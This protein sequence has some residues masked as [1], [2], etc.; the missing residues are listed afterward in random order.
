MRIKKDKPIPV[1][2]MYCRSAQKDAAAIDR[3]KN[4]LVRYAA[5]HGITKYAFYID[6]GEAGMRMDR[7][8]FSK[9]NADIE[10][11]KVGLV[12]ALDMSRVGRDCLQVMEWLE[13]LGHKG[14]KFV[15]VVNDR[16][17]LDVG[18]FQALRKAYGINKKAASNGRFAVG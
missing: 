14:V 6:D 13:W 9:M 8:A 11:G 2:A 16:L 7:P 4:A 5:E 18:L 10:S 17:Q 12:L 15:A 1:A 3:Q